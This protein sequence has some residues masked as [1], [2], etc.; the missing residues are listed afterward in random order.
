M[1]ILCYILK[2]FCLFVLYRKWRI[3]KKAITRLIFIADCCGLLLAFANPNERTKFKKALLDFASDHS[4][5]IL[6][7]EELNFNSNLQNCTVADCSYQNTHQTVSS[8]C[9]DSFI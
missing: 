6:K 7:N 1:T 2:H 8:A 4:N 3:S 9:G 5:E